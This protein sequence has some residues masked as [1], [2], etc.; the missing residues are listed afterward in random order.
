MHTQAL[1][2]FLARCVCAH[3]HIYVEHTCTSGMH[4]CLC[5]YT[6]LHPHPQPH[7]SLFPP[8]P[9]PTILSGSPSPLPL[10]AACSLSQQAARFGSTW[11]SWADSTLSLEP[12]YSWPLTHSHT[13]GRSREA[14]R[15]TFGHSESAMERG[16]RPRAAASCLAWLADNFEQ[17]GGKE[18][19]ATGLCPSPHDSSFYHSP[20]SP[21]LSEALMVRNG[22]GVS[23]SCRVMQL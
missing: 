6:S 15:P 17:H 1:K 2:C 21:E 14:Q 18:M 7:C 12:K 10:L 16:L 22:L 5:V 4:A 8:H 11:G 9:L 20:R 19:A 13:A 23:W 3:L